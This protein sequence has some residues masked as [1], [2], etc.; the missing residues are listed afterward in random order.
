[1]KIIKST[2]RFARF[3]LVFGIWLLSSGVSAQ[4][5]SEDE[6]TITYPA[7]YFAQYGSVSAKDMID[8]IPGVGSTTGGGPSSHWWL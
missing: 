3:E 7:S 6:A 5:I 1:M 2:T 8:R 4:S